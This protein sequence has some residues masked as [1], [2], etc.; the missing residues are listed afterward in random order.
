MKTPA[1]TTATTN[2]LP[3]HRLVEPTATTFSPYNFMQNHKKLPYGSKQQPSRAQRTGNQG[4]RANNATN[5]LSK[6]PAASNGRITTKMRGSASS[7]SISIAQHDINGQGTGVSFDFT[8]EYSETCRELAASVKAV[9]DLQSPTDP[10]AVP[11]PEGFVTVLLQLVDTVDQIYANRN[12]ARLR[13]T[14]RERAAHK[15]AELAMQVNEPVINDGWH[16]VNEELYQ[17]KLVVDPQRI[18]DILAEHGYAHE[19]D[20][21]CVCLKK[22]VGETGFR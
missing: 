10:A 12:L 5:N 3:K 14:M 15:V 9:L 11:E 8:V 2:Q 6:P 21:N 18:L 17:N 13:R 1:K 20:G 16:R 4:S 19:I 7:P 22:T